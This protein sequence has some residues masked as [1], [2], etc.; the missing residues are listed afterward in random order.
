MF[1]MG[2]YGQGA[3]YLLNLAITKSDLRLAE[4]L[5]GHGANPN[6]RSSNPKVK[7]NLTPYENAMLH[8]EKE[9][10]EL[11]LRHGAAPRE[12]VLDEEQRFL[13]ACFRLDRAE[14]KAHVEK[15][16]EYLQSPRAM[17]AAAKRDRADV[18]ELLLDI[19]VPIEVASPSNER[20]LHHA[21]VTNSLSAARLLIGRGAEIDP[22]ETH[23]GAP[24]IGWAAHADRVEMLELLSKHS[25][26]IWTLA[27]RGFVDRVSEVLDE[28]SE[29]A[30]L[31][32]SDGIT[33]LWWLPDN[34]QKAIKIVDLLIAHGADPARKSKAG[35]TAA[36]WAMTRGMLEVVERLGLEN[37]TRPPA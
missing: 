7:P 11:L 10:A 23:Y 12:P 34:E 37:L 36:D 4:W 31:A 8:G 19:G 29:L 17:F 2:G 18:V 33:P 25:R 32:D 3:H 16:P 35:R 26:F 27:F 6:A 14:V 28:N 24:P 9:I 1:D 13:G 5:L 30:G 22:I 20:A 15:H 21:A